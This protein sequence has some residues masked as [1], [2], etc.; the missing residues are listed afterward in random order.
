MTFFFLI[1]IHGYKLSH[2]HCRRQVISELL[3]RIRP[4]YHHIFFMM[5]N[6][7]SVRTEKKVMTFI[8]IWKKIIFRAL[9][10]NNQ[11]SLSKSMST[12]RWPKTSNCHQNELFWVSQ[13]MQ[14]RLMYHQPWE[15]VF[16]IFLFH[17]FTIF[18]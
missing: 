14:E 11:T 18:L 2:V 6:D 4:R 13:N 3:L 7:D 1:G 15:K 8:F 9:Q 16:K 12:W 17:D 10:Y 5:M